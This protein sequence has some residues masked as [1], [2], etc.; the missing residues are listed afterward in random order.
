VYETPCHLQ[1]VFVE[2][3]D[4]SEFPKALDIC[5]RHVCLP[6]YVTMTEEDARY[7]LVSLKEALSTLKG[8]RLP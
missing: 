2:Y 1:P 7:V 6:V 8:G 5:R 4:D 3:R